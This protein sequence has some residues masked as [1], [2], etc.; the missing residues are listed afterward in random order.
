[1][2]SKPEHIINLE[3]IGAFVQ[4]KEFLLNNSEHELV[5]ACKAGRKEFMNSLLVRCSMFAGD[6]Q[7]IASMPEI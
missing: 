3:D 6:M 2:N 4:P 1:M 5:A 7:R